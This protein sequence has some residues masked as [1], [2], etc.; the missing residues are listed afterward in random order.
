M[1]ALLISLITL[2]SFAAM[3]DSPIYDIPLKD[4][5]K[6]ETSL[7]AYAGKA[8]LIVNVASQ[9]GYTPQYAGLEALWKKY[10]AQGLVVL[11]FPCNDFGGQEPGSNEEIKSFCSANYSVSFPLFD[12]VAIK[13]G[14]PHPLYAELL[15]TGDVG[16]NFTK[17]LVGK[18]GKVIQVFD[19]GVE[20]DSAELS[21]AIDKA[22]T[23]K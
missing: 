4:I 15:K 8:L 11:G 22:L 14:T 2:V 23:A 21:S 20:P 9:C 17:F 1:K 19:S 13:S 10:Q 6:K 16:W 7:K 3:A 12:K 5:D 18:D